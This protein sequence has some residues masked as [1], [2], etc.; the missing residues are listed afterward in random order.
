MLGSSK[1]VSIGVPPDVERDNS[2]MGVAAASLLKLCELVRD[3]GLESRH[4]DATRETVQALVEGY[5][6]LTK[7]GDPRVP[8]ILTEGC[9]NQR[10]NLVA[11]NELIRGEVGPSGP[12]HVVRHRMRRRWYVSF[13]SWPVSRGRGL[14][15][16][17]SLKKPSPEDSSGAEEVRVM[18]TWTSGGGR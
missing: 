9:Y 3:D 7:P 12:R 4:S 8:R 15:Q 1:V 16:E 5:L 2:A 10:I 11:N 13:V 17:P 14:Y 6:T 18:K